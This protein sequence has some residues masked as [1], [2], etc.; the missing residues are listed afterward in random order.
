MTASRNVAVRTVVSAILAVSV[1]IIVGAAF[2]FW[3]RIE[4]VLLGCPDA[5]VGCI[6]VTRLGVLAAPALGTVISLHSA[7]QS[8]APRLGS[9]VLSSACACAAGAFTYAALVS[10]YA[11]AILWGE[12]W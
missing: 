1:A 4:G 9:I 5:V 3:G 12:Y 10:A 8:L 11:D 2:F 6:R 7:P